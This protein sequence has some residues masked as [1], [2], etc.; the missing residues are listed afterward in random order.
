[1]IKPKPFK[2]ECSKCSFSK[3]VA[4]TSDVFRIGVDIPASCPKCDGDLKRVKLDVLEE[5]FAKIFK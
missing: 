4:P 3:I 2:V 5:I 1:M